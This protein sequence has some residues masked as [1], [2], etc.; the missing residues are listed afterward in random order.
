MA[1][2]DTPALAASAAELY[3]LIVGEELEP[4]PRL[5]DMF[6]VAD[7][8]RWTLRV[9]HG[10]TEQLL[11]ARAFTSLFL[12]NE[13]VIWSFYTSVMLLDTFKR[14]AGLL[15]G[16]DALRGQVERIRRANGEQRIEMRSGGRLLFLNRDRG[17]G[18]R[19]ISADVHLVDE[20]LREPLTLHDTIPLALVNGVSRPNPQVV[21]SA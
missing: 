9:V 17:R 2:S 5:G 13:T 8:G 11:A 12:L 7:D 19:G 1:D 18:C 6:A 10:A 20:Y 3:A 15:D 21:V 4:N 16:S 14:T